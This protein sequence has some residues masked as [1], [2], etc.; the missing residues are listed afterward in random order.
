MGS[1]SNLRSAGRSI[2]LGSLISLSVAACTTTVGG[3]RQTAQEASQ[4]K[5]DF[6][7]ALSSRSPTLVTQFIRTHKT[8]TDS[9]KLLNQMPAPVLAQVPRSAVLGLSDNVKLQLTKR[10][11]GQFAISAAKEPSRDSQAFGYGG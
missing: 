7:E 4:Q 9:A 8:S 5:Q 11:R 1:A 2:L 3:D 10:V 6:N